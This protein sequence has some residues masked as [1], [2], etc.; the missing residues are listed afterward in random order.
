MAHMRR[1]GS[2][3]CNI[4]QSNTSCLIVESRSLDRMRIGPGSLGLELNRVAPHLRR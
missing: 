4:K 3:G 1:Y 2:A